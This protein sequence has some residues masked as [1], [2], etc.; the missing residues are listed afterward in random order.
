MRTRLLSQELKTMKMQIIISKKFNKNSHPNINKNNK[1]N[2]Y[3]YN[4][5]KI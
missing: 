1:N 2:N 5:L 4:K 3:R